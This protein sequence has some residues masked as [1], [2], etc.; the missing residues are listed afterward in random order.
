MIPRPDESTVEFWIARDLQEPPGYARRENLPTAIQRDIE[1]CKTTGHELEH[2]FRGVPKLITH[3]KAYQRTMEESALHPTKKET[4]GPLNRKRPRKGSRDQQ[5][6]V[7]L[8]RHARQTHF[9]AA[10]RLLGS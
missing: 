2:H 8:S 4:P 5:E 10:P 6:Q 7:A 3:G 1:S 9:H